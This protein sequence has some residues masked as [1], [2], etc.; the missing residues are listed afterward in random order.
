[1]AEFCIII[2]KIIQILHTELA[3]STSDGLAISSQDQ[4]I[5]Y[6]DTGANMIGVINYDGTGQQDFITTDLLEPRGIAVNAEQ[7][8]ATPVTCHKSNI[9]HKCNK[10]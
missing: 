5:Y 1:M 7:R 4:R 6:A 2:Y 8:Y 3:A 9:K 10:K